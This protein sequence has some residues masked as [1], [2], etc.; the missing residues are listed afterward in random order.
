MYQKTQPVADEAGD[1]Q[2]LE[3][4]FVDVPGQIVAHIRG[5][6]PSALSQH[7][8][9]SGQAGVSVSRVLSPDSLG[10]FKLYPF[11]RGHGLCRFLSLAFDL[12]RFNKAML[13]F[14]VGPRRG[15]IPLALI[16][17]ARCLVQLILR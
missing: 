15:S 8:R 9:G 14:V 7:P 5:L 17:K 13:S 1:K 4:V 3:W 6:L 16:A 2:S 12:A 10:A 11:G